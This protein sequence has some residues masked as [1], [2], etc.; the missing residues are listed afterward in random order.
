MA[1]LLLAL[2]SMSA[3]GLTD[4]ASRG[5]SATRAQVVADVVALAGVSD[6]T[7]GS[8]SVAVAND[9]SVATWR[10]PDGVVEVTID[11][12]GIT[13]SATAVGG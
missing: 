11:L 10:A 1:G 13:A 8:Q 9:A 2:V 6:G 3:A 12:R 4:E 5:A 7:E